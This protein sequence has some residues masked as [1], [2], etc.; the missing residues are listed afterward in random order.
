MNTVEKFDL[1]IEKILENWELHHAIRELLA[2]ALDEQILTSTKEVSVI[3]NGKA[4][5]I[6]DYGRG[7][8]YMHLTQNENNEKLSN[9][10]VIGKFGIG[11]K[12]ALATFDRHSVKVFIRSKF[13]D[14]STGRFPKDHFND[15]VTLHALIHQASDKK[16]VGT[17][18][19]MEGISDQDMKNA[20]Q[21]FLRFSGDVILETTKF[22]QVVKKS[23]KTASIYINGVKVAEE[24][25]FLFSYNITLLNTA[26]KKSL[27]RE[28]TNVGRTAYSDSVKKILLASRTAD[29][30]QLLAQDLQ[31]ISK[32]TQS[33]ELNWLDVQ[34]HAVKILNPTGDYL[35]LSGDQLLNHQDMID[36]A[37]SNGVNLII[38]PGELKNRISGGTDVD[39]NAIKD[40]DQFIHDYNDS[41]VFNFIDLKK[42]SAKEKLVFNYTGNILDLIGGKPRQVKEIKVSSTMRK[43]LLRGAQVLGV[44][45]PATDSI[46][47]LRRLL[48][49]LK[50]Y[51]GILIHEALHARSGLHDVSRDFEQELTGAIGQVCER[52]LQSEKPKGKLK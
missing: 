13:S 31:N 4:W 24:P 39:G 1:N 5:H 32:G 44:W 21:L 43:D 47:I 28:R 25:N 14:I 50:E 20:K 8:R 36:E 51:S 41:F 15:I 23:E 40:I 52:A 6:R 48:G 34:E 45:D 49:S 27:N 30:A 29:V 38:I 37:K 12:D 18:V 2:N 9:P 3:K 10:K 33:D 7:L 16:L 35:F 11:L 46:I 19:I 17:E 42:L 26:I 22:G